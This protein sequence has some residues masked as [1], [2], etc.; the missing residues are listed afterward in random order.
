MHGWRVEGVAVWLDGRGVVDGTEEERGGGVWSEERFWT[1]WRRLSPAHPQTAK[2]DAGEPAAPCW[3]QVRAQW[4]Q[5]LGNDARRVRSSDDGAVLWLGPLG[6]TP[7]EL[8]QTQPA[9]R[10]RPQQRESGLF[11]CA[12]SGVCQIEGM[13]EMVSKPTRPQ[14]PSTPWRLESTRGSLGCLSCW[15]MAAT[16]PLFGT[17]RIDRYAPTQQ[18]AALHCCELPEGEVARV[19]ARGAFSR[20]REEVAAR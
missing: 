17:P 14:S 19:S 3:A 10:P 5:A 6:A 1:S 7:T 4:V 13:C 8:C 12:T 20:H 16:S 2:A 9:H 18:S 15:T 11:G